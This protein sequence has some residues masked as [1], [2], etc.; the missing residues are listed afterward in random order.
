MVDARSESIPGGRIMS[1]SQ[2]DWL[3]EEIGN[4]GPHKLLV[5][6]FGQP[7]I[8]KEEPGEDGW[9]GHAADRREISNAIAASK[10]NGGYQSVLG[11]AGDAHMLAFD[12]G[13]NTDYSDAGGAGFPLLQAGPLDRSG[14]AKGGP[15]TTE[16]LAYK[17]ADNH[18]YGSLVITDDG[19]ND[20]SAL[21]VRFGMHRRGG[22]LLHEERMCGPLLG[23]RNTASIPCSIPLMPPAQLVLL[24]LVILSFIVLLAVAARWQYRC[25]G[26]W[27]CLGWLA[28][29]MAVLD[30]LPQVVLYL[31]EKRQQL[32]IDPPWRPLLIQLL[33][34]L[35]LVAALGVLL[36]SSKLPGACGGSDG[37]APVGGAPR[38]PP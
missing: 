11:V 31:L 35:V 5:L 38:T 24:V 18:Q 7:W 28:V 13:T 34:Q 2:M 6:M 8:G 27:K 16:C 23:S 1:R 33:V 36:P 25:V 12:D 14:S 10:T 9:V 21:C 20:A 37:F 30:L 19:G 26:R 4:P 15:Y 29:G 17:L 32:P 22:C 3:L